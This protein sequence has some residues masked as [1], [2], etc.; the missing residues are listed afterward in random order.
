MSIQGFEEFESNLEK[1]AMK[2]K[3]AANQALRQASFIIRRN[4]TA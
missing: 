1:L 2:N 3:R 4:I